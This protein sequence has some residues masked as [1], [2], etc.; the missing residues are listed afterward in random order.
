MVRS[1]VIA[2]SLVLIAGCAKLQIEPEKTDF[3]TTSTQSQVKS[4]FE[5]LQ[6]QTD[7]LKIVDLGKTPQG[8]QFFYVVLNA[9]KHFMPEEA[10]PS[11]DMIIFIIANIHAGEVEGKEAVQILAR[12]IVED[13]Q[14]ELI[15]GCTLVI[16]PNFNPDGNDAISRDNRKLELDK[17]EGQVNPEGGVGTRYTGQGINLNRDYA[18]VEAPEMRAMLKEIYYKWWP[19]FTVDC[20]TTDGS[21]HGYDI[22]YGTG[23]HPGT[24]P[25]LSGFMARTFF[26]DLSASLKPKHI[27]S[28]YYGNFKSEDKRSDGWFSYSPLVRYGSNY[29]GITGRCDV[30]AETYSYI[31]FKDRVR[32]MLEFLRQTILTARKNRDS[33]MQVLAE[34]YSSVTSTHDIPIRASKNP[35]LSAEGV[36][37]IV[38]EA[39]QVGDQ[40]ERSEQ[41]KP[42]RANYYATFVPEK[43]IELPAAYLIK[44]FEG[45][46]R[47]AEI[48]KTHNFTFE[49]VKNKTEARGIAFKVESVIEV[50]SPDHGNGPRNEFEVKTTENEVDISCEE[51]DIVVTTPFQQNILLA[52]L[53][54]PEADDGLVRWGKIPVKMNELLPIHRILQFK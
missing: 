32:V 48:L 13:S 12:D 36:E 50:P 34:S 8:R 38:R 2:C 7:R 27:L 20:H 30:L 4:F 17:L 39:K 28:Y 49:F 44:S 21:I 47:V 16:L 46:D 45:I 25:V 29:R 40:V 54:E 10:K 41:V 31:P 37:I 24:P 26:P 23:M 53:L 5:E 33:L 3:K 14:W 51:G 42:Y 1:T 19:H 18:K 9:E 6:K 43:V 35:E 15:R 52:N 11:G 22:T